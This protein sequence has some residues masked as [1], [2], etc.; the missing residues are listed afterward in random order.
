MYRSF[1]RPNHPPFSHHMHPPFSGLKIFTTLL[2][3]GAGN[4]G[5]DKVDS[6]GSPM[7]VSYPNRFANGTLTS[8]SP[9]PYPEQCRANL[10]NWPP[11]AS[12]FSSHFSSASHSESRTFWQPYC[13]AFWA[14]K[15]PNRWTL[16]P[17]RPANSSIS[18]SICWMPWRHRSRIDRWPPVPSAKRIAWAIWA[19]HR[20]PWSRAMSKPPATQ[21]RNACKSMCAKRI[22]NVTTTSVATASSVKWEGEWYPTTRIELKTGSEC[23]TL[24]THFFS[25]HF[26]ATP[27]ASCWNDK[28]E[29]SSRNSTKLVDAADRAKIVEQS[30]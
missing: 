12:L 2:G 3:G 8:H 30:T 16:W 6:G 20:S 21:R 17:S 1:E 26:A 22:R 24:T 4:D 15:I 5:I 28:P 23:L 7:Q 27:R 25:A 29:P 13:R 11:W 10:S 18:L 9:T 14:L 19:S